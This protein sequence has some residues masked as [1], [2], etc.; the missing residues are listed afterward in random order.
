MATAL[1]DS[2][3]HAWLPLPCILWCRAAEELAAAPVE[4][5]PVALEGQMPDTQAYV[6]AVQR[7]TL[8]QVRWV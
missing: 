6:Q 4:P 3:L 1:L 7:R 5:V 2:L 8:L